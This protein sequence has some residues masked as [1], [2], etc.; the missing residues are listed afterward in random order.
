[1]SSPDPTAAA[2]GGRGG[3]GERWRDEGEK[4]YFNKRINSTTATQAN[5]RGFPKYFC[6]KGNVTQNFFSKN[7]KIYL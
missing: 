5:I 6:I 2:G 7:L 1:M 3:G 4:N